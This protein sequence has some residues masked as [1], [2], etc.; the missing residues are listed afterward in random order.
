MKTQ[1]GL[2]PAQP[3]RSRA[4]PAALLSY[5]M[6]TGKPRDQARHLVEMFQIS[7]SRDDLREPDQAFVIV[8]LR[9]SIGTI[10]GVGL[11]FGLQ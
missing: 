3:I 10:D 1:H 6:M 4:L 11:Q 2:C 9:I 5:S 7:C 8:H